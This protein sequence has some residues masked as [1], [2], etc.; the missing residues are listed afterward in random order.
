MVE[1]KVK[2]FSELFFDYNEPVLQIQIQ[3]RQLHIS[4]NSNHYMT[5]I[6]TVYIRNLKKYV[7]VN[8]FL[9]KILQI[10]VLGQYHDILFK[11]LQYDFWVETVHIP[12]IIMI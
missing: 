3:I 11:I 12:V 10:D 4:P 6:W 8:I 2:N 5:R 9:F 1:K 7:L